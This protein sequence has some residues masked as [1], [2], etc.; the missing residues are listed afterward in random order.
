MS[1]AEPSGGPSPET[2]A[3]A[4]G[5]RRGR[6]WSRSRGVALLEGLER[7][8]PGSTEHADGTASYALAA[9][10]ELGFDRARAE[11]VREAARLHDV[12]K[13]Y[14]PTE[15]LAKPLEELATGRDA[16]ASTAITSPA[17]SSLPA[18]G[19]PPRHASGSAPS[20]S[21]S[22]ATARA[23]LA[24]ERD[25]G[26]GA[27]HPGGLRL[28]RAGE[29]ARRTP[30]R[31]RAGSIRAPAP[32]RAFEAPPVPS[33]TRAPR[34][35]WPRCWNG[36][37]E[38]GRAPRG[39][40]PTR[41]R[42]LEGDHPQSGVRRARLVMRLDRLAHVQA[43]AVLDQVPRPA[44]VLR[45]DPQ[46]DRLEPVTSTADRLCKRRVRPAESTRVGDQVDQA[47]VRIQ[48]LRALRLDDQPMP[49]EEPRARRRARGSAT[50]RASP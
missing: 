35:C 34:R 4:G 50:K 5:H 45:P 43:A 23:G 33:W 15:L 24:G 47:R 11:L 21:A 38:R 49:V 3:S 31:S 14:V 36:P 40:R 48:R 46:R 18:P 10:V 42:L 12:G 22:T 39:A 1:S 6:P 8:L 41:L 28:R 25:P 27:G 19:S 17:R 37:G 16:L 32:L 20:A 9:A 7:H 44:V 29:G 26:R 30:A 2:D 13:V